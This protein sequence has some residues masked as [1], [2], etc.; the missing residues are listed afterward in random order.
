MIPSLWAILTMGI[1]GI[2]EALLI[3][4]WRWL[5]PWLRHRH[6]HSHCGGGCGRGYATATA[7]ATVAEPRLRAAM[8]PWIRDF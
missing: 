3:C 7:T 5:W 2:G 6:R 4:W 8:H 1:R